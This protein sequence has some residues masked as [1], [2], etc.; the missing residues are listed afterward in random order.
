MLQSAKIECEYKD[1]V[2]TIKGGNPKAGVFNGYKDHRIVMSSIVLAL[3]Q[4]SNEESVITDVECINK[5]Y[6]S[7]IN[8]II[9][10]GGRIKC[11][12]G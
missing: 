3:L 12:N 6:P 5:S 11:Q 10:L 1:K 8:D 7:F 2:M 4:N 9:N